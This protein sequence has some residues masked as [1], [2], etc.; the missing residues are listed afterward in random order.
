MAASGERT[1]AWFMSM[2][3]PVPLV[4]HSYPLWLSAFALA[5]LGALAYSLA[6][7]QPYLGAYVSLRRAEAAYDR[8]DRA[9]AEAQYGDVLREFPA[10]ERARIGIAIAM[11][12]DRSASRQEAGLS[13]LAGIKLGKDDYARILKV[14]PPR[15]SGSFRSVSR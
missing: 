10:S 14:L 4:R 13:Y 5:V 12:S 7:A 6:V 2:E 15:F 11:L 9:T 1:K 8:G 3:A